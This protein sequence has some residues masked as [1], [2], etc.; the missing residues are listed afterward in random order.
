MIRNKNLFPI[1]SE[2]YHT[3]TRQHANFHQPSV[4]VTGYQK[5]VY[6][7]GVKVFNILPS[8]IK[9]EFDNPKKFKVI[10]QKFLCENSF[11]SLDEYFEL[12]KS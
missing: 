11:Y 4:N 7:L 1:N 12:Y 9:T 8:Y 2:I 6:Y 5:G 3:N 10:L